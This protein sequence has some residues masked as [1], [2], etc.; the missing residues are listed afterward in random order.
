MLDTSGNALTINTT[1]LRTALSTKAN[2]N[3]IPNVSDFINN[4]TN[5]AGSN[6][7]TLTKTGQSLGIGYQNLMDILDA[8]ANAN[9]IPN[10]SD[11]INSV[12]N[13]EGNTLIT[14]IKSGQTVNIWYQNLVE[15][16]DAKASK[17]E[18]PL[19]GNFIND[20]QN[21]TS[22]PNNLV[23]LGRIFNYNAPDGTLM[24]IPFSS[25]ITI[26]T[27]GLRTALNAKV[28][29]NNPTFTGTVSG[30]TK[31]MVGLGNVDNT[32][33]AS[34]PISTAVQTA[35]DA[36]ASIS[37]M[38]N[39]YIRMTTDISETNNDIPYQLI[40]IGFRP[41][42][43]GSGRDLVFNL[44][45]LN[46]Q[47]ARRAIANDPQP[48][49]NYY[50]RFLTEPAQDTSKLVYLTYTIGT[51]DSVEGPSMPPLEGA[52]LGLHVGNLETALSAKAPTNN[53]TFTGTVSG[54]TKAMVGLDNVDNTSDASK[55][56]STATQQ[57]LL[58]LST[59]IQTA[60]DSKANVDNPTLT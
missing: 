9:D 27:D 4:V 18:L 51:G 36:K 46:N 12:V 15:A 49:L 38:S 35:L 34:K 3:A 43:D 13:M 33:D 50:T 55:P 28:D 42:P 19:L 32:S 48:Y 2:A 7:I 47:V 41:I 37:S 25:T 6:L 54:I 56:M 26:S 11:F 29:A 14:L 59:T 60:L 22:D 10:V 20:Y 40:T 44:T 58:G 30:I 23:S 21:D 31:A 57:A 1:G 5:M 8:K 45:E 52:T 16:L 53:P 39:Y 17:T 24:T